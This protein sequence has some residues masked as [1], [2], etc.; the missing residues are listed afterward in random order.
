M[1]VTHAED[2]E[3]RIVEHVFGS[4]DAAPVA[5]AVAACEACLAYTVGLA[6]QVIGLHDLAGS[7]LADAT[8]PVLESLARIDALLDDVM[9]LLA[10]RSDG[11]PG[12]KVGQVGRRT[13]PVGE[14]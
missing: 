12:E 4:S 11:E 13:V 2:H 14:E 5:H 7:R 8:P 3:V 1:S 6:D 10:H 9:V